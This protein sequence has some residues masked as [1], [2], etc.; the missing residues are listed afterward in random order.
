MEV[1]AVAFRK[2][3]PA[4]KKRIAA[5]LRRN[6]SYANWIVGARKVDR[7]RVAFLRAATWADAIKS[8]RAYKDDEQGD[9]T[10]AQN[11]GYGDLRRHKYWHYVDRPFS[12]D[13]TPLVEARTPNA[14]TQIALFRAVLAAPGGDDGVKSYDLT[15]LLHLVGDVHQPLH[16]VSRFD[17]DTPGG[18]DGGNKVKITGNTAPAICEDPRYCPFGPPGELHAFY[19]V[20][21]G[22]S[23][24]IGA[25]ETAAAALPQA[26][27][28]RA[29]VVDEAAWIDEGVELARSRIYVAPIGAGAGPFTIDAAYQRAAA[30]LARERI[31]LAGARLASLLN[32]CFRK[33]AAPAPP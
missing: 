21:T 19:D 28:A 13:G 1:A 6:P 3:T 14:A 33:E 9:P 15:W 2:L 10:A 25:V 5:L 18:D 32:D 31:S 30:T 11:L 27:P 4:S 8:D 26:R 16:C 23:Y 17:R 12:S 20:L 24:G 29:R 22:Q 7:D